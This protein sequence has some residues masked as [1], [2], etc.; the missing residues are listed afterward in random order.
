MFT[1]IVEF[2][3]G[4]C[5]GSRA[6]MSW[7]PTLGKVSTWLDAR[8]GVPFVVCVV[9][10]LPAQAARMTSKALRNRNDAGRRF[11]CLENDQ[12]YTNRLT[13]QRKLH[14]SIFQ[15]RYTLPPIVVHPPQHFKQAYSVRKACFNAQLRPIAQKHHTWIHYIPRLDL[16]NNGQTGDVMNPGVMFLGNRA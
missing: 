14:R 12:L 11:E 1:A 3:S 8:V 5:A 6:Q 10:L 7:V 4:P 2:A 9:T 16:T 15:W 13:F